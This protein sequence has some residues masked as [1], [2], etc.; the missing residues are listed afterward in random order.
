MEGRRTIHHAILVKTRDVPRAGSKVIK[1]M[2]HKHDPRSTP[3][4][5]QDG[6]T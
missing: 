6:N 5:G 3:A 4:F 1:G 2:R